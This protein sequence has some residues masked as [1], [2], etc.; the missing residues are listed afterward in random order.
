MITAGASHPPYDRILWIERFL[1]SLRLASQSTSLYTREAVEVSSVM[2]R[3][4]IKLLRI[5]GEDMILTIELVDGYRRTAED[6][7]PY[8]RIGG[9]EHLTVIVLH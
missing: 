9:N 5:L 8:D 4:T 1:Q 6:V 3:P 2:Q 7:C